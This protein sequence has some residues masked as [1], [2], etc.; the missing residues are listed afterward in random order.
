MRPQTLALTASADAAFS[1]T[2]LTVLV[3]EPAELAGILARLI[4]DGDGAGGAALQQRYDDVV[5]LIGAVDPR[6]ARVLFAK[7]ARAVLCLDV[8]T[9]RGLLR[10]AILPSL[11]DGR[12]AGEAVLGEFPDVD[13]ADAL[14]LLLDL[15][16]AAPEL[17]PVALDRLR[18]PAERRAAL[19]P[20]IAAKIEGRGTES[21]PDQPASTSFDEQARALTRLEPGVARNLAEF[22]AFDLSINEST[23]TALAGVRDAVASVDGMDAQLACAVSLARIEANPVVV[24]AVIGRAVPQLRRLVRL[25]RWQ[26]LTRWVAR[27]A[28]IEA[29][30]DAVRPDAARALREAIALFCDRALIV[31]LA[32]LCGSEAGRSYAS[33]IAESLNAALAIAWLAAVDDAADRARVR[34]LAGVI[35]QT[36][37]RAASAVVARLPLLGPDAMRSALMVLGFAGAGY[38]KAIADHVSPDDERTTREALRAL[39]RAGTEKA[40][41]LIVRRLEEGPAVVQPAAE[42]ALWRL[43]APTA[44]ARTRE[45]LGRRD[46]VTRH[47][48]SAARLLERAAQSGDDRFDPV[49]EQLSTLRFHF[50]S[51]ALKRVGTKARNLLQ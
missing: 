6:L 7:L 28:D 38:E 14:S 2:D 10:S 19:A 37:R 44:L 42:E 24:S 11:L 26:D 45:L 25:Q 27:I 43:P 22:S 21:K 23:A 3:N 48:H 40:A 35:C 15:E 39:A 30:V 18:L 47:P 51:P 4:D 17:L 36:A 46:F 33:A 31:D 20:L 41:A 12:V 16:A 34:P 1:L 5:M 49:L 9:R 50:W 32:Q 29:H 13:L 8:D